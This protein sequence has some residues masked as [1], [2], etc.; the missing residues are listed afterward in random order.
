MDVT[1][2]AVCDVTNTSAASEA[3]VEVLT[4]E[5]Y[6]SLGVYLLV[7]GVLGGGENAVV[8]VMFLKDRD[9]SSSVDVLLLNLAVVDLA[10]CGCYFPFVSASSFAQR[11]LFG[12]AGCIAYGYMGFLFGNVSIFSLTAIS[13]QRYLVICKRH[14]NYRGA[15]TFVILAV[16][17][18]QGVLWSSLPLLLPE[19]YAP[20]PFMTSCTL[21][22]ASRDR[23]MRIFIYS[24]VG[25]IGILFLIL[26]SCYLS[27]YLTTRRDLITTS[28][29][30]HNDLL[31]S[32]ICFFLV[33]AFVVCWGPYAVFSVL[34]PHSSHRL[35]PILTT[36][37]VVL[38]KMSS[39]VN[40]LLYVVVS[41]RFRQRY[42][43][44]LCCTRVSCVEPL[45]LPAT[46]GG[47]PHHPKVYPSSI[48]S[49]V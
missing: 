32:K 44:V 38:A 42:L 27:I 37:P 19:S 49:D 24:V 25:W 20:E 47:N 46:P 21:A 9:L 30:G 11:W 29:R 36:V 17:W 16:V 14:S 13:V 28:S 35:P 3:E 23:S 41:Q 43:A 15:W 33:V 12:E 39:C 4:Q 34:Y 45:Q 48:I 8:V 1:S 7:T 10:M 26:V 22:W 6:F 2:E 18:L 5:A 31:V 40:P